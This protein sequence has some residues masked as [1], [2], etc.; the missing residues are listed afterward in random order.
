[1]CRR[2]ATPLIVTLSGLMCIAQESSTEAHRDAAKNA[3]KLAPPVLGQEAITNYVLGTD[4]QISIRVVNCDEINDKP[5]PVDLSGYIH[6]P[7][8]GSIKVSGRTVQ[9]LQNDITDRLKA[10]VL[11]PDASVVV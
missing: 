4:D 5:I 9:Q 7:L 1:M 11:H 2:T 6:L 3:A 8:V 10:Y